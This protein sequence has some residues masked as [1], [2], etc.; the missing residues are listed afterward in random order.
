MDIKT[1]PE[2]SLLSGDLLIIC[3][4]YMWQD[5]DI[6]MKPETFKN[7]QEE[8]STYIKKRLYWASSSAL[9]FGV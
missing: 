3:L 9:L 5:V 2:N 1:E 6:F 7:N 4:T 8:L